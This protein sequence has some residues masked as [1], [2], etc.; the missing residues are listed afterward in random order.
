MILTI[1]RL[2]ITAAF[3][4][5]HNLLLF[6]DQSSGGHYSRNLT[7]FNTEEVTPHCGGCGSSRI[8]RFAL[9]LAV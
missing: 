1:N 4:L 7:V 5:V 6:D 8:L 9:D 2:A 3:S